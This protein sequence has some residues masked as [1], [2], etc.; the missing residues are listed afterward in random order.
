[1]YK[2]IFLLLLLSTSTEVP[3][4]L[5]R[6]RLGSARAVNRRYISDCVPRKQRMKASAGFVSASALGMAFGPALAGFLQLDF[7]IYNISINTNTMPGWVMAFS[8]LFYLILLS[9]FFKEPPRQIEYDDLPP[10]GDVGNTII[11]EICNWSL[12]MFI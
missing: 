6:H 1:M 12:L 8:W 5:F 9:I 3:Y 10:Q 11:F 7:K 2:Y 4:D